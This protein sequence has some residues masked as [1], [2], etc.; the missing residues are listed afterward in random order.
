MTK[1]NIKNIIDLL[2]AGLA[3]RL[4]DKGLKLEITDAAKDMIVENGYDP[5]YGARPLKRYLQSKVE[6]MIARAILSRDLNMGDTLK[7]DVENGMLVVE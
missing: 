2:A 3:R 4:D 1:D 7:V 6:T 5:V